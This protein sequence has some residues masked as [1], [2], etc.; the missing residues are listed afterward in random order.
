MRQVLSGVLAAGL[1]V[2]A[3]FFLRFWRESADRLFGFFAGAFALMGANALALGLTSPNDEFRVVLY[4]VRLLAFLLIFYAIF[5]KNR[6]RSTG[7][8]PQND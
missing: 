1:L 2:A 6:E 4:G 3:L 7:Q 5:D 8:G